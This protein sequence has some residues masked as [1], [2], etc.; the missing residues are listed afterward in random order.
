M[1]C[2]LNRPRSASCRVDWGAA[3]AAKRKRRHG[4]GRCGRVAYRCQHGAAAATDSSAKHPG[5]AAAGR[6]ARCAG[7][8]C[9]TRAGEAACRCGRFAR[10]R[11]PPGD[12]AAREAVSRIPSRPPGR[13]I[14]FNEAYQR[15]FAPP[16]LV[17]QAPVGVGHPPTTAAGARLGAPARPHPER[18]EGEADRF[19]SEAGPGCRSGGRL[20]QRHRKSTPAPGCDTTKG[21]VRGDVGRAFCPGHRGTE[22][23]RPVAASARVEAG[24]LPSAGFITFRR[25]PQTQFFRHA[26]AGT[27]PQRRL[28]TLRVTW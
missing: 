27:L 4:A 21:V 6:A 18:K 14:I 1:T 16:K 15:G 25:Q 22:R 8:L 10:I 12:G 26:A 13:Q 11:H 23:A 24:S 19:R 2:N 20:W 17:E 28:A 7:G 5:R 9:G 3:R